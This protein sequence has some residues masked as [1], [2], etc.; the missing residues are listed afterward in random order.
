MKAR[1]MR[2]GAL[3]IVSVL[4]LTLTG[5]LCCLPTGSRTS[6]F[7]AVPTAELL[8]VDT[9]LQP[10]PTALA[11][12]VITSA[13]AE[14]LLL[15]NVYKRVNPSVVHIRVI[16]TMATD[17]FGLPEDEDYYGQGTGSGFVYDT[18]GHIVTNN[19]V[20]AD[21]KEV[22]VTFPDGTSVMAEV[23]G[24]DP[25]SDLAV[26]KVDLPARQLTPV[27]LGDSDALQIG[28]RAIAIGNP[29][30]LRS[31]L[32][33][34]IISAL[35]RSLPLGRLSQ[36]I[37]SR[38]T[39]PELIQTDA[40]INPGNSGGPLLDSRGQVIGVNTAYDPDA[41]GVG[42]AVPVNMVKL[43]VPKLI[44]DGR[45]AYPWL[46]ISGTDLSLDYVEAM[47]LPVKRG[48]IVLS[49][50]PGSPADK[51][52]LRGS[53]ETV[54]MTGRELEIGGDVI[55]AINGVPVRQF[56]D[57]LV[58]VIRQTEVGQRV[59]LT[60]IRDGREQKI[61]VRLAERPRD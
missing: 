1:T 37:G 31:T 29:Y 57:I 35:G 15:I 20:V 28:Q 36:S 56:E 48:A 40:A 21:G 50:V 34:G 7:A 12:E 44:K 14:E 53:N 27:E 24:V 47:S 54:Q 23:V 51:A 16:A 3:L 30:G 58:Y 18:D 43:V 11:P 55:V 49:V 22:Q 13:D 61:E 33:T 19:H 10:T 9:A 46:G 41:F 42:F 6:P 17:G 25:D 52:G 32:T 2:L 5:C 8:S 26:I 59:T 38:F 39:I 60:I 45:Y 4:V